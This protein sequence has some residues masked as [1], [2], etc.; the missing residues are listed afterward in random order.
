[1]YD[2]YSEVTNLSL[3]KRL[4]ITAHIYQTVMKLDDVEELCSEEKNLWDAVGV[5]C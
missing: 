5:H 4:N 2:C 1:M 3:K